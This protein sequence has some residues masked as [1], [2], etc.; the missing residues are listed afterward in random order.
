M[1]TPSTT[2]RVSAMPLRDH[3]Q[4]QICTTAEYCRV[5]VPSRCTRLYAPARCVLSVD[6]FVFS[7]CVCVRACVLLCK[8]PHLLSP[9][10]STSW[11]ETV[12]Q[13]L[14]QKATS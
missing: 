13:R 10:I 6:C 8:L 12:V 5:D 3:A 4:F 1:P 11:F 9:M 7:V 14:K 2:R